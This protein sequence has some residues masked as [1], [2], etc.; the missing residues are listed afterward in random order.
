MRAKVLADPAG[1]FLAPIAPTLSG[2]DLAMVNLETAVADHGTPL[3]KQYVFHAPPVAFGTLRGAGVDVVTMANNHGTDYGEV[4]LQESL[5]AAESAQFPVVGL[6]ADADAAYAPWRIEIKG[7]RIAVFGFAQVV[8]GQTASPTSGGVASAHDV[9]RTVAAVQAAR[10]DSDTIVVY[11]HWGNE[12]DTCPTAAQK[13]LAQQLVDAGADVV[14]GSHAHRQQG[15]GRL[16]TAFVDY[17]LGNFVWY[18]ES[19]DSGTTGVLLVTVT[20]RDTDSY[21][22]VPARIRGGV[23]TPLVGSAATFA[24]GAWSALQGCSG[25][26]P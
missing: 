13:T 22:W 18:N 11:L 24:S 20:G 10:A 9:A 2:A 26:A 19:G 15:A 3:D 8:D 5:A 17:G 21:Q 4:G 16:G 7:Q 12:G 23:P 1:G 6:G 14:V 25:L